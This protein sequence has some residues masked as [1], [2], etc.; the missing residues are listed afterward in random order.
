MTKSTAVTDQTFDILIIGSGA[1]GLTLALR[2]AD[3]AQVAVLSKGDLN[4]G[5]TFYAQGGIAAVLDAEDSI[6]SHVEDTLTAGVGLC[7]RDTVEYMLANSAET[8]TW[9]IQQGVPF[10]TNAGTGKSQERTATDPSDLSSL[11]LTQEG[12]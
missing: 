5:A 12:G 4:Q 6:A 7:D 10:T 11:H 1:A 2:T 8:I 3:F 9:L